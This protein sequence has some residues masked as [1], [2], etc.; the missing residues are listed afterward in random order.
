MILLAGYANK[1]QKIPVVQKASSKLD[2]LKFF[3]QLSWEMKA[4]DN[5]KFATL[6]APLVETG[7]MLG[8]WLKQLQI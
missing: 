3:L 4:L 1:A 7:K 2:T 5:K 6:S 8:G